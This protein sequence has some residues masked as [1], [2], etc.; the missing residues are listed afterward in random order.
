MADIQRADVATI[1]QEAYSHVLL[2]SAVASS[3][4]LQAFPTVTMGS[5]LTHLP[6]LATVPNAGWVTESSTDPAAVKPTDKVTWK[7]QTLS[8]EEVAV[9]I[10]VHENV[11]D[12]ATVDVI[13]EI[14]Q[15]GG[16]AI[17]AAL[18]AAVLFGT[19]K[20]ASWTSLDLHAAA[21]GASQYVADVTGA[22]NPADLVGCVT[23]AA[24]FLAARGLVPDT[25]IAPLT[26]RYD[27]INIRDSMGAP[28]FRDEQFSGFKTVF[29]RNGA[30][31]PTSASLLVCDSSRIRIGIRTDI[32]V[33]LLDQATVNGINL[34]ERDMIGV[35][36]LARYAYVLGTGTT[37]L[38][39][40]SVPVAAV[41]PAGGS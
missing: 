32:R 1:I 33:K 10:P 17:G 31:V 41:V 22:A 40:N 18:D 6:V 5:K 29:N 37:R 12:D 25:L 27:V 21:H 11:L 2:D 8:A 16:E 30:W 24:R 26:F 38:G 3:S 4:V 15:R 20:P 13:T 36:M 19:S 9:I 7:D 35:R 14:T 39:A 28:I 34:A 23:Q